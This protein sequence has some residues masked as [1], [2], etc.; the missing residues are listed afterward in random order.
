MKNITDKEH[1][2]EEDSQNSIERLSKQILDDITNGEKDE[3][4]ATTL[5]EIKSYTRTKKENEEELKQNLIFSQDIV[6]NVDFRIKMMTFSLIHDW[7]NSNRIYD[8]IYNSYYRIDSISP[9]GVMTQAEINIPASHYL[10]ELKNLSIKGDFSQKSSFQ[11]NISELSLYDYL[12]ENWKLPSI[13]ELKGGNNPGSKISREIFQNTTEKEVQLK[14]EILKIRKT[15][16]KRT[17]AKKSFVQH[18]AQLR[19]STGDI[20]QN[21]ESINKSQ[22]SLNDEDE[23]LTAFDGE[24]DDEISDN[25]SFKSLAMDLGNAGGSL[26]SSIHESVFTDAIEDP[27]HWNLNR[28]EQHFSLIPV[29]T[30]NSFKNIGKFIKKQY[31]GS[32]LYSSVSSAKKLKKSNEELSE[33]IR[34]EVKLNFQLSHHLIDS[35]KLIGNSDE[36][37]DSDSE[38]EKEVKLKDI[39][40]YIEFSPPKDTE[41]HSAIEINFEIQR[42]TLQKTNKTISLVDIDVKTQNILIEMTPCTIIH[43]CSLLNPFEYFYNS[44]MDDI[45]PNFKNF[46]SESY[47]LHNPEVVEEIEKVD[48]PSIFL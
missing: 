46:I 18:K 9:C 4:L 35:E 27:D 5:K 6:F 31:G 38:E 28:K 12:L 21:Q 47:K 20:T 23:F 17:N 33:S 42:H 48:E 32:T 25:Q 45:M 13:K 10:F 36:E 14:S 8:R 44:S 34:N 15:L 1:N 39:E 3:E 16:M 22:A 37:I 2:S 19:M 11:I 7:S 40:E 24:N 41:I 26:A 29:L 30:I 43:C